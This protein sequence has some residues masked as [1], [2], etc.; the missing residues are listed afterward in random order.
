MLPTGSSAGELTSLRLLSRIAA[1]TEG[2]SVRSGQS[3]DNQEMTDTVP[4]TATAHDGVENVALPSSCGWESGISGAALRMEIGNPVTNSVATVGHFEHEGVASRPSN[5]ATTTLPSSASSANTAASLIG[6]NLN[7]NSAPQSNTDPNSN[8][9]WLVSPHFRASTNSNNTQDVVPNVN[10]NLGDSFDDLTWVTHREENDGNEGELEENNNQS[11]RRMTRSMTQRTTQRAPDQQFPDTVYASRPRR[12]RPTRSVDNPSPAAFLTSGIVASIDAGSPSSRNLNQSNRPT[13]VESDLDHLNTAAARRRSGRK[14]STPRQ[15][16]ILHGNDCKKVASAKNSE[17]C[18]PMTTRSQS[19]THRSKRQKRSDDSKKIQV[20]IINVESAKVADDILKRCCI[21]L[22]EPKKSE[23]SKLNSCKHI[24]CF[25][26]I[27]KWAERENTCPLCKTR[28][29]KIE[30]VH[31][32]T[33][34]KGKRGAAKKGSPTPLKNVKKVKNRDQRSDYSRNIPF[35]AMLAASLE[36]GSVP[37]QFALSIFSGLNAG[38]NAFTNPQN[39]MTFETSVPRQPGNA[40]FA[41]AIGVSQRHS[42]RRNS[43]PQPSSQHASTSNNA[44]TF[45]EFAA[46]R[47]SPRVRFEEDVMR[48]L[49]GTLQSPMINRSETASSPSETHGT[50]SPFSNFRAPISTES[51][52]TLRVVDV[53]IGSSYN[54]GASG[55]FAGMNIDAS[56]DNNSDDEDESFPGRFYRRVH[57]ISRERDAVMERFHLSSAASNP[58]TF[59]QGVPNAAFENAPTSNGFGDAA[60]SVLGD[61]YN[62]TSSSIP[63]RSFAVNGHQADAGVSADT[64]LE[65]VDSDSDSDSDGGCVVV[66]VQ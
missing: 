45:A 32:I 18:Q 43:Q 2:F 51:N 61:H 34:S 65:I 44:N 15:A 64:A 29:N 9:N 50:S 48:T 13:E 42:S 33:K 24:Y 46:S 19:S 17:A 12:S 38:F 16:N 63:P 26:C 35:R 53:D 60:G 28:F 56:M 57:N 23:L 3:V 54:R 52:D 10:S 49:R 21:C 11:L 27:E 39:L 5:V 8:S 36:A 1:P 47:R 62:H 6:T 41:T 66:E 22:E 20:P 4:S 30:R 59:S 14:R 37:H 7:L 55:S 58:R 31:K 25:K 40:S